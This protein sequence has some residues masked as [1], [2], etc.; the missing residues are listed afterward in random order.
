MDRDDEGV[1]DPFASL[2]PREL[3]IA[4]LV[5]Q[6]LTNKAI[7]EMLVISPSTVQ[8]HVGHI[9]DKLGLEGRTDLLR[10]VLRRDRGA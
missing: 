3:E 7:A 9:V 10:Y 4:E 1:A 5:G 8:T 2:T 6:G